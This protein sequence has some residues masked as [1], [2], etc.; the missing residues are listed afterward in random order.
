MERA[1]ASYKHRQAIYDNVAHK[2]I[3]A[4]R[5][6]N[7]SNIIVGL[8]PYILQNHAAIMTFSTLIPLETHPFQYL[9]YTTVKLL[10]F[11]QG[12]DHMSCQQ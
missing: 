2:M 6:R 3:G 11:I 10:C 4:A 9:E 12:N 5:H 1:Q 7:T 8:G